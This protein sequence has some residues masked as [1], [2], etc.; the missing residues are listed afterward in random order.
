MASYLVHMMGQRH[1]IAVD[2]PFSAIEDLMAEASRA[3]F[4]I[5]NMVAADQDGVLRR[6]I[7]STCR[8]ECVVEID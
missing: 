3:K 5:G 7:I 8:I 4:L 2:L 6:V 1:P